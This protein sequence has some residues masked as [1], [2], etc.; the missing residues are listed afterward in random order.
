MIVGQIERRHHQKILVSASTICQR[1]LVLLPKTTTT[2]C[3]NQQQQYSYQYN[4]PSNNRYISSSSYSTSSKN[5]NKLFDTQ[6]EET[7]D[8][9][10]KLDLSKQKSESYKCAQPRLTSEHLSTIKANTNPNL[11]YSTLPLVPNKSL[12]LSRFGYNVDDIHYIESDHR[13]SLIYALNNGCNV[14]HSNRNDWRQP[15]DVL[16]SVLS[17]SSVSVTRRDLVFVQR[18]QIIDSRELLVSKTFVAD[19]IKI[20]LERF[21]IAMVDSFLLSVDVDALVGQGLTIDEIESNLKRHFGDLEKE[22]GKRIQSYGLSS[23]QLVDGNRLSLSR[24]SI[25]ELP[26]FRAIE[27][28]FNIYEYSSIL[29]QSTYSDQSLYQFAKSGKFNI[30]NNNN[31]NNNKNVNQDPLVIFNSSPSYFMKKGKLNRFIEVESHKDKDLLKLL[32]DAFDIAIHLERKNPVFKDTVQIEQIKSNPNLIGS[33]RWAHILVEEKSR[34]EK[35]SNYWEWEK[36]ASN[37][38]KPTVHEA[39]LAIFSNHIINSWGG[40]Y[41][42]AMFSLFDLY[43]KSLE[44]EIYEKQNEMSK[45]M[46]Q[47]NLGNNNNNTPLTMFQKA[48]LLS[49]KYS[50]VSIEHFTTIDRV[51]SIISNIPPSSFTN[52][53]QMDKLKFLSLCKD[54][55]TMI[56]NFNESKIE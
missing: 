5:N 28:P 50:D 36:V 54:F 3:S 4:Q 17:D 45:F 15:L 52:L 30:S 7:I 33:M 25:H 1:R 26:H 31:N 12:S 8:N 14:I 48:N 29:P 39:I 53:N 47:Y 21:K 40:Q 19:Q 2:I 38:I 9:T 44:F 32:K 18:S 37:R 11:M 10:L 41:K 49:A 23:P 24:L 43:T 34:N 13:A 22:C 42:K 55:S 20:S 56:D 6:D 51:K 35:L 46:E 27:Y 16:D